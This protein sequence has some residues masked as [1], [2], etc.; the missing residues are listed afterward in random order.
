MK[1]RNRDFL[2]LVVLYTAAMGGGL[3]I[4][5][6]LSGYLPLYGVL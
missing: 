2:T 4:G 1:Q 6:L 3:L 5:F